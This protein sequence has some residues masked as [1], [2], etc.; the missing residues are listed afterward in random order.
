MIFT[1]STNFHQKI[2]YA[3]KK[4]ATIMSQNG[5]KQWCKFRYRYRYRYRTDT[6]T[7]KGTG[8]DTGTDAGTFSDKGIGRD[9]QG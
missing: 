4:E 1:R 6:G 9:R 7:D 2:K 8:T 5:F 3:K